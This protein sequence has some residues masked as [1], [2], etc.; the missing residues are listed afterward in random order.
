MKEKFYF[1]IKT[2][3][4][5][6]LF[7]NIRD[8]FNPEYI[9]KYAKSKN[10][11]RIQEKITF[12]ALEL[13]E[14]RSSKIRIL[15]AGCGPGFAAL[16]LKEIGFDVIALDV[17]SEF[18]KYYNLIEIN[19][20]VA[21][22]CFLPFKPNTFDAIVSISALQW[23]FRDNYNKKME[24]LLIKLTKSFYKTL[25]SNGK[26]VIQ[27][28]PKNNEIMEKIGNLFVS[29]TNFKGNFIIDNPNNAKKRKIFLL[30][31]KE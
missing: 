7:E 10:M 5:E 23:I 2:K 15:D 24:Y 11:R 27:F 18:L 26:V 29:N 19:P 8:Y 30:L 21:D 13:L 20:L 17:I 6:E 12:R 3:R 14:T 22:M 28:Y 1:D 31:K 16:Y 25:K 9:K 4:P